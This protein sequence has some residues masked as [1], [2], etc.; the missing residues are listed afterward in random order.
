M[1]RQANTIVEPRN[2]TPPP[3]LDTGG[4]TRIP[5]DVQAERVQRLTFFCL[6][7]GGLWTFGLAM[8][9]V[10]IPLTVGGEVSVRGV[11][12]EL[13]GIA[14]AAA[15]IALIRYKDL[16]SETKLLA[17]L[18]FVMVNAFLVAMLNTWAAPSPDAVRRLSWN[19]ILILVTS[20]IVP[21]RPRRMLVVSLVVASMDPLVVWLSHLGETG[22]FSLATTVVPFM[23]SYACAV[24]ATLQAHVLQRLGRQL[25]EARD[26]GNYQLI[27]RLGEGGMGEV[28]RA[29]HRFLARPA[30]IK[31]VR[32]EMLGARSEADARTVLRR[33]E[34]EAHATAALTSPHTINVFDVGATR[35]HAFY[36]VMELLA[37]RDM[38][39]LVREFGPVPANR[40]IYLLQQ[41]CQSLA[42]AHACGLIH[43]DIKPANI[44]ICRMGL[45]YD[46]VK[47]L[48]F[49]LVA[50][51]DARATSTT[52]IDERQTTAGTPAFMA[53]ETI[54]GDNVVD[55]RA[56]VYAFGCVAY[57]LL[58]G[59]L[60]FEA[61][62]QIKLLLEHVHA[63]PTPPSARTELKIPREL[64]ELVLACLQKD[65][66]RRPQNAS[67]LLALVGACRSSDP[68]NSS[69]AR[70]WWERHL[71]G[72]TDP[73]RLVEPGARAIESLA[74]H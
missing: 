3:N 22:R 42:E 15:G 73:V 26:L 44:Y 36:Y 56:D 5:A 47:V 68:W 17:G 39:T 67:E 41:V 46:F 55:Q 1:F 43:R 57:Y 45:E 10:I 58:T 54:L 38:D 37:G 9:T 30:A 59:H 61:P 21:T 6:V 50:F 13:F 19:A 69:A 62:T 32:P 70:T 4:R 8:R 29:Q 65:P 7:L 71:P 11:T 51:H 31:L 12:I 34:R 24:V 74:I 25:S 33:F 18:W 23:P 40:A 66:A 53:P 72:L 63:S 16:R 14:A 60:V 2:F 27:E 35:D 28:W 48:D 49:G 20:T 52:A 64:D